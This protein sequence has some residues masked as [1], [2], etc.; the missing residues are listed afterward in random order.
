[1]FNGTASVTQADAARL[2]PI[3]AARPGW[4][5]LAILLAASIMTL[6]GVSLGP[7]VPQWLNIVAPVMLALAMG[8]GALG[9][10]RRDPGAVWAPLFWVRIVIIAFSGIGSLVPFFANDTTRAMLDRFFTVYPADMTKY[11]AVVC[12]FTLVMMSAARLACAVVD[13]NVRRR[14]GPIFKVEPS[15]LNAGQFG[16][17]ALGMAVMIKLPFSWMPFITGVPASIPNSV[18]LI[19]ML[20][21]IAYPLLIYYG[22]EHRL[23]WPFFAAVPFILI[24]STLGLL[25]FNKTELLFPLIFSFLGV[26]FHRPTFVRVLIGGAVLFTAYS[27][28]TPFAAYGRTLQA[29]ETGTI[30]TTFAKSLDIAGSYDVAKGEDNL[31]DYQSGWARLTYITAGSF[32]I[33]QYDQGVPGRTMDNALLILVPRALYPDKPNMSLIFAEFNY[34]VTGNDKSQS[35]P[36]IPPEGYWNYGWWGVVGFALVMGVVYALWSI[37]AIVTLQ[38]GAWHLLFVALLGIRVAVRIDGLI[39][40]DFIPMIPIAII[41]HI[42]LSFGNR[43]LIAYR[44]RRATVAG[45]VQGAR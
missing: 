13:L 24:E 7:D 18:A 38:A 45:P 34:A 37:Y 1:M 16:L 28:A 9:F 40:T 32:A 3:V 8:Y 6:L 33:S 15:V 4:V 11:N 26:L 31:D 12:V 22:L 36:G 41:A 29:Q 19:G 21:Y 42:G 20:S 14:A 10:V 5:E 39:V 2:A 44:A 25:M 30:D 23:R 27:L 43:M 17:V 35:A